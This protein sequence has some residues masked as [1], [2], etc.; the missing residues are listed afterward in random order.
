[1]AS[2]RPL[3]STDVGGISEII[4]PSPQGGVLVKGRE[5]AAYAAAL[6]QVLQSLPN[7]NILSNH[8]SSFAW[9]RCA[10]TYLDFF[11]TKT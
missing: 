9:Q 10:Q 11:L 7:P 1:M 8:A 3:V 4:N 5:K 6:Q 2:G